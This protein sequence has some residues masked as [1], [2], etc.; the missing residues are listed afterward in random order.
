M[1]E[2]RNKLIEQIEEFSEFLKK[3]DMKTLN[4]EGYFGIKGCIERLTQARKSYLRDKNIAEALNNEP[5]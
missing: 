4:Y 2:I 1:N 3:V 5:T